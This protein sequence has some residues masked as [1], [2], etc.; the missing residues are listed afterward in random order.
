MKIWILPAC[1]QPL[2]SHV[3]TMWRFFLR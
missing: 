1:I 2:D 3:V